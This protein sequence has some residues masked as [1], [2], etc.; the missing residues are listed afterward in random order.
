MKGQMNKAQEWWS[1]RS[2]LLK[3]HLQIMYYP[4]TNY[5]FFSIS[6][7]LTIYQ[8]EQKNSIRN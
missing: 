3:K 4:A 6:Q 8:N 7:I 1:N 2:P 5:N